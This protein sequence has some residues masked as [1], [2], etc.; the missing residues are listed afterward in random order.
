MPE[1]EEEV[2]ATM[3]VEKTATEETGEETAAEMSQEELATLTPNE[4]AQYRKAQ[5][6]ECGRQMDEL[7]KKYD[8]ALDAM[9]T[10]RADRIIPQVFL[11]DAKPAGNHNG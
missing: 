8:C 11:T 4:F 7:M 10:I 9:V 6:D 2:K 1:K 5:R 3:V